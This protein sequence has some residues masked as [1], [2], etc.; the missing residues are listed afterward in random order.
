MIQPLLKLVLIA[1]TGLA[2][3]APADR[4]ENPV[5]HKAL[6]DYLL[7]EKDAYFGAAPFTPTSPA[8]YRSVLVPLDK[9]GYPDAL[10]LMLG[11]Y[12]G[13]TGGQTLFVFRGRSEGF[14][15][16]SRMTCIRG[17]MEGSLCVTRNR[18]NGW[19]DLA[20]RVSGGEPSF[21][22]ALMKFDGREYP[23]NPSVGPETEEY[24]VGDF[25]LI[26]GDATAKAL[27]KGRSYFAG[28]LGKK[29]RVQMELHHREGVVEG[30]YFY[31]RFGVPIDLRGKASGDRI[32]LDELGAGEEKVASIRATLNLSEGLLRG[33]W[34]R[35]DGE[36]SSPL[37]LR[38]VAGTVRKAKSSPD[39]WEITS[40]YPVFV[41]GAKGEAL[42]AFNNAIRTELDSNFEEGLKFFRDPEF[43]EEGDLSPNQH[44]YQAEIGGIRYF[45]SNLVSVRVRHYEY[46]GGA[47]GNG[48]DFSINLAWKENRLLRLKLKDLFDS[49]TPWKKFLG[50]SLRTRL[51]R[52]D[53]L[54]V[55][56]GSVSEKDL[57]DHP[58]FTFSPAGLEFHFAPYAVGPYSQGFFEVRFPWDVLENFLRKDELMGRWLKSR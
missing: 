10:V 28:V 37:A 25:V 21:R 54:W 26:S 49:G 47:H 19:R 33:E 20:V 55:V 35:A 30:T 34:L 13:G 57:T 4:A 48:H 9:D 17:P 40:E 51:L 22:F 12:W 16:V 31:E 50:K 44:L 15:F 18:T 39:R 41:S 52:R 45:S 6:N 46:T 11:R 3:P 1:W 7:A 38:Q 58:V 32:T 43:W 14:Q 42:R 36:K 8:E 24:P 29:M 5:L 53:A 23:L 27:P 2:N 56:E